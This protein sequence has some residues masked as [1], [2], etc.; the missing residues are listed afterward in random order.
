MLI[1]MPLN[2]TFKYFK[3]CA[4][5]AFIPHLT[6]YSLSFE[7]ICQLYSKKLFPHNVTFWWIC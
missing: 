2:A 5:I 7:H 3:T 1:L 6:F 4:Y